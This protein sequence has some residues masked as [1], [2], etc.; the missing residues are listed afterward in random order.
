MQI[1][2]L[3]S[4]PILRR[5]YPANS[6]VSRMGKISALRPDP[7]HKISQ[8]SANLVE[9]RFQDKGVDLAIGIIYVSRRKHLLRKR[10]HVYRILGHSLPDTQQL[11]DI[12]GAQIGLYGPSK[13]CDQG[14]QLRKHC[15]REQLILY[16]FQDN[17]LIPCP[18]KYGWI[19]LQGP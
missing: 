19:S 2:Q 3:Y 1:I 16:S 7:I 11:V 18:L 9:I 10:K 13:L 6:I 17:I 5:F 8:I 14:W 12:I 4:T 15:R